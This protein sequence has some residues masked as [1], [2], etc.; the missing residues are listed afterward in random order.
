ME[1]ILLAVTV[2]S[3]LVALVM[4]AAAWRMSREERARAGARVA[5]L[6][7][8]ASLEQDYPTEA[9]PDTPTQW[10]APH[11]PATAASRPLPAGAGVA[12]LNLNAFAAEEL[13][14]R[15]APIAPA[16]IVSEPAASPNIA[17]TF[18]RIGEPLHESA[19]RQ[20]GLAFAA[21]IL[22]VVVGGGAYWA[23]SNG[24]ADTPGAASTAAAAPLELVSL[25]HERHGSRLSLAG[26][27]RNPS[28]G[29]PV[30]GLTT[31]VF[32]FDAQGGFITSGRAG[33]DFKRIAPGDESPFVITVEAPPN[34]ARYRVSFRTDAG[35]VAHVDRRG[36]QPVAA[37]DVGKD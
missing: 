7:A 36:E 8:A 10:P 24:D 16:A 22:F 9:R 21:V 11:G 33:I 14:L 29:T 37:A 20:R 5:A 17:G 18:L 25:R 34:V 15:V 19:G 23:L 26:L 32:L 30:E 35:I 1:T 2:A 28:A 6:A 31:V 12:E 3:L 4:S 27:V 13:P